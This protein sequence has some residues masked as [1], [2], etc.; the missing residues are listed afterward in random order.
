[1]ST[2]LIWLGL[3]VGSTLGGFIP[4][5]WG[6]STFSISSV[7]LSGVGGLLGIYLGYRLGE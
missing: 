5:V 1:M 2:K 4:T 7:I 3:F 6:G